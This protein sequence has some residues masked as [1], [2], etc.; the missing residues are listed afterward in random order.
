LALA[1]GR[2]LS[3][4]FDARVAHSTDFGKFPIGTYFFG[5]GKDSGTRGIV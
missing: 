1:P 5:D 4:A 2:A 3:A